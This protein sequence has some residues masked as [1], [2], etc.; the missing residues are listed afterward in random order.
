MNVSFVTTCVDAASNFS[1]GNIPISETAA[2]S[3]EAMISETLSAALTALT[4]KKM[5]NT[6]SAQKIFLLEFMYIT[7]KSKV[8]FIN[9]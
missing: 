6:I 5:I 1:S 9:N 7:S 4:L 2:E 8:K 3:S